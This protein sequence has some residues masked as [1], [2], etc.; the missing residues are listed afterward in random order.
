MS[1]AGVK[2]R[3]DRRDG[4]SKHA[5]AKTVAAAA[6]VGPGAAVAVHHRNK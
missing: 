4:D 2:R 5:G 1:V 3:E 6:V